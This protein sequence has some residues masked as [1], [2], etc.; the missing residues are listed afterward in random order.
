MIGVRKHRDGFALMLVMLLLAM[1]V[2][3][4]LSYLSVASIKTA[5]SDNFV[6]SSK[7]RYL[8]E[9][10]LEHAMFVIQSN[11]SLL[12][13]SI[14][15]PL[16]PYYIDS[17]SDSYVFYGQPTGVAG[18]YHITAKGSSG[19]ITQQSEALV[20]SAAAPSITVKQ[21]L[22]LTS[23]APWLPSSLHVSG[24]VF[25]NGS[26]WN[27]AYIDGKA[28][29]NGVVSD[30]F[31][32]VLHGVSNYAS[33]VDPPPLVGSDYESYKLNGTTYRWVDCKG[34]TLGGG[35]PIANGGAVTSGNPG[36]VIHGAGSGK[37]L[38]LTNNLN[39]IGTIV[40]DDDLT[41]DGANITLTAV[42]GFPAI[43]A[44]RIILTNN[45]HV[46]I[47]G[48]VI[49]KL[50]FVASSGLGSPSSQTTL[51]G[52]LVS[53]NGYDSYL[54]GTQTLNYRA[55]LSQLYDVRSSTSTQNVIKLD[56]WIR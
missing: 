26:L 19:R 43:V 54:G 55:N 28:G 25:V 39:Y 24:D 13:G 37:K 27:N 47:N 48:P 40:I 33:P 49:C 9:S 3:L 53:Q 38:T 30:A 44:N 41:I 32:R 11:P 56:S 5:S 42:N 22:L 14:T 1:S 4:G 10:G 15:T 7:A 45:A 16:G 35:D 51:N 2:V 29:A 46:T 17:S 8:A 50:G 34:K 36:G 31:H 21:G 23:G 20:R 18:Q 52:C 12:N 6:T